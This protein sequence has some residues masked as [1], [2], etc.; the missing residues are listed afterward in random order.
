MKYCFRPTYGHAGT[1]VPTMVQIT[2]YKFTLT[3]AISY[4]Y[5]FLEISIVVNIY[6]TLKSSY[7]YTLVYVFFFK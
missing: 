5:I 4:K 2:N 7:Q 6:A 3:F 1:T